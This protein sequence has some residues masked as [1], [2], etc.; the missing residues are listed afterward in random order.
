[1]NRTKTGSSLQSVMRNNVL[2]SQGSTLF[3][4]TYQQLLLL[5]PWMGT[6]T[7]VG[8]CGSAYIIYI[9]SCHA[10]V[11]REF[12][13]YRGTSSVSRLQLSGRAA[14]CFA[15]Q[16]QPLATDERRSTQQAAVPQ[17]AHIQCSFR[18]IRHCG[19]GSYSKNVDMSTRPCSLCPKC[20]AK[21]LFKRIPSLFFLTEIH[22]FR[23][24]PFCLI[25][26]KLSFLLICFPFFR[27]I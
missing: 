25:K 18:V 20:L 9:K 6:T 17:H 1:M 22:G 16:M 7:S 5:L 24:R 19:P 12:F 21:R 15:R 2:P 26:D 10:I 4:Q 13:I 14:R 27:K 8:L 11:M 3:L 23:L